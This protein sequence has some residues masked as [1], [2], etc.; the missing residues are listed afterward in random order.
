MGSD[1]S[2]MRSPLPL[3]VVV[4]TRNRL[5]K[6]QRC[7]AALLAATASHDWELVIVDNASA[8]GTGAYLEW[9][10]LKQ[11]NRPRILAVAEPRVGLAAAR[12]AG[13]RSAAGEIVAFTD[14]D[15]YVAADYL[16]S[17]VQVFDEDARLGFLSGRILLFDSGDYPITINQSE[18]RREFSPF[19]FIAAGAVQGANLAFRRNI[20]ER[21][22]GFDER[23]GA[24]TPFP[25]E[26]IDAAA[27]ALWSGAHGVYDPRP[28]VYHHHGRRTPRE[29]R[30]LMRRYDAG[31]GAYY[32]KYIRQPATR[33]PYLKAWLR[34]IA[35]D[36]LKGMPHRPM[37]ELAAGL[38]FAA[39][40]AR[41]RTRAH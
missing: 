29:V 17:I 31:R 5:D 35:R 8:D 15:C 1:N 7:V 36:C 14:D 2:S 34:S 23:L 19:R 6:L 12:N 28:L 20:L 25:S 26:D 4:C 39:G 24:G 32:A 13:W 16:D 21:I 33:R 9:L 22:G 38:R 41:E 40:R 11:L 10:R 3:S 30:R 18:Q 37:R 27:A